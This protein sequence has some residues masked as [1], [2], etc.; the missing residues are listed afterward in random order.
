VLTSVVVPAIS[1][2]FLGKKVCPEKTGVIGIAGHLNG[3][4]GCNEI[5]V[6]ILKCQKRIETRSGLS[7]SESG[8]S[9]SE[10]LFSLAYLSLEWC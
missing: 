9:L 8:L 4:L 10:D 7:V 5:R 1:D 3:K 2:H 6:L